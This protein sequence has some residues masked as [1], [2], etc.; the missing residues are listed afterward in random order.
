MYIHGIILC[1]LNIK[2]ATVIATVEWKRRRRSEP[3]FGIEQRWALYTQFQIVECLCFTTLI[4]MHETTCDCV[5][6]CFGITKWVSPIQNQ[7]ID[8]Y[9]YVSLNLFA[10]VVKFVVV[11]FAFAFK[12]AAICFIVCDLCSLYLCYVLDS[13]Q[14]LWS[15]EKMS[16]IWCRACCVCSLNLCLTHFFDFSR[17]LMICPK[18]KFFI[19]I[20]FEMLFVVHLCRS[21]ADATY[22]IMCNLIRCTLTPSF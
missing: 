17:M 15:V 9:F 18:K 7:H 8:V 21:F 1:L 5:F 16:A 19:E 2:Y 13:A 6:L 22:L 20:S 10:F 4:S 14:W 12:A 11:L 3:M